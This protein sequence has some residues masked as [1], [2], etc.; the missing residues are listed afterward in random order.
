[1]TDMSLGPAKH[2]G[3]TSRPMQR[4]GNE[5]QNTEVDAQRS[6]QKDMDNNL[7]G[8][9]AKPFSSPSSE[10]EKNRT[11]SQATDRQPV[12]GSNL[13]SGRRNAGRDEAKDG[14]A[15]P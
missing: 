13:I 7:A 9:E 5:A 1:M 12:E 14:S 11:P 4:Q 15:L 3:D 8:S 2:A 6:N 10:P